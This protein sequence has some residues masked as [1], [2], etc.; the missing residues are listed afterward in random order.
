MTDKHL[1]STTPSGQEAPG[2]MVDAA[3]HRLNAAFEASY[4]R[5]GARFERAL[6]RMTWW[7]LC[8]F[9]IAMAVLILLT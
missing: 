6:W 9:S 2:D 4:D 5:I 1:G 3:F 7:N 8:V